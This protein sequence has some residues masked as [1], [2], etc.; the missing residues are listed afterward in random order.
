MEELLA[1]LPLLLLVSSRIAGVTTASPIF[2][3]RF[4]L[5]SVRVG[6]TL[7]LALLIL[8]LV[9]GDPARFEGT[10]LLVGAVFELL[11]GLLIGFLSHMLFSVVQM[12]GALMDMEMGLSM[13]NTMDPVSGHTQP[14]VGSFLHT[15]TLVLYFAL[16]AHHWLIRALVDSYEAV[17]VGGFQI[18]SGGPIYAVSLFGAMLASAVTLVMPFVAVTLLTTTVMAG[19]NRAVQQMH[20][21][22]LSMGLKAIVGMGMLLVMLPYLHGFL[23]SL[24]VGGHEALLESLNLMR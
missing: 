23:E 12:A 1:Q 18:L 2:T 3:N 13:A 6:F 7:L 15:L 11:I 24:F 20:L 14:V 8:P 10:G 9:Q 4:T 19:I 16:G 22:Q 21:F 17:G 5:P